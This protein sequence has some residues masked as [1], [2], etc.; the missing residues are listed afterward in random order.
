MSEKRAPREPSHAER[1]RTLAATQ[2][3]AS[4][5][6]LARDPEGFP[7]GSLVAYAM[8]GPDPVL[9]ISQLAEHTGNL[10]HDPRASLLVAESGVEDPLA[11]GRVTL[12]GRAEP[13]P[14]GPERDAARRVT[15]EAQPGAA[16]YVDFPDFAFWK[17]RVETLRYIG[18]FGRMSWVDAEAWRAAEPDPIA[19][20]AAGILDHMNEDHAKNMI[21]F[22]RA[23]GDAPRTTS[24][25]M[26]AID[27]YGFEMLAAE[28]EDEEPRAVRLG[29]ERAVA[30]SGEVRREMVTLARNARAALGA[31]D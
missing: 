9:L 21:D 28:S 7:Y 5:C 16:R 14:E 27:R 15:L 11:R 25:R 29:F 10:Q 13:I 8:E 19:P 20:H 17:L 3:T 18:G 22:C 23:F 31:N 2:A 4:L 26:T 1:A 6:T 24:V 12:L 30:T